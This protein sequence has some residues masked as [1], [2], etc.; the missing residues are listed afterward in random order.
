MKLTSP[1]GPPLIPNIK[2][3]S[4]I[5]LRLSRTKSHAYPVTRHERHLPGIAT[6]DVAPANWLAGSSKRAY[7]DSAT[8]F[9]A[10]RLQRSL[11]RD[12]SSTKWHAIC[13]AACYAEW[14]AGWHAEWRAGWHD[15]S[16]DGKRSDTG[17]KQLGSLPT[18]TASPAHNPC[19]G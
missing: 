5:H 12:A 3:R 8:S 4:S 16:V 18:S 14:C 1:M 2:T 19:L 10:P 15:K 9:S 13:H 7:D 11:L 6:E 17:R